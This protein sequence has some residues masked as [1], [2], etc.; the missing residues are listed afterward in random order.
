MPQSIGLQAI[1]NQSFTFNANNNTF[2]LILKANAGCMG[3]SIS[4]N[5][6]DVADN[7]RCVAWRVII[8]SQYQENGNFMF[9]TQNLQLPWYEQFGLMQT[10]VYFSP[11]ELSSIRASNLLFSPFGNLPLRFQPQGYREA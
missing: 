6:V 4:I 3:M 2:G 7:A 1:P 8:P 10:L 9:M 5:G 11:T